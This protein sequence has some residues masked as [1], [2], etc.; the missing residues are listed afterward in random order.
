MCTRLNTLITIAVVVSLLS[1][2]LIAAAQDDPMAYD[3]KI[4]VAAQ[5]VNETV[6]LA[7]MAKVLLDEQTSLD[8]TINTDF[9]A[10]SVL[11]Q[12]M[13]GDEID[14]YPTWTGTQLTGILRYEGPNLSSE[15]TYTLVKQGFE[16]KFNMTWSEPMGFNN[17]YIMAVHQE[18]AD[19]YNLQKASD[20]KDYAP[21][22]ILAGDEN[23]DTRSDAYPG[24]SEAYGIE[25]KDVLPMQYA[26]I[27]QAIANKEVDV[28]AAYSTDSRIEKLNLTL[29]PDDKGFFPDYSAAFV[30]QMDLVEKFPK[31]LDI[32]N[33]LG[34]KI[35]EPTMSAMNLEYDSGG[36][37]ETIARE[38]LTSAGLLK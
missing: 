8:T 26:M 6:I 28:I 35:D 38:F 23:F 24:W 13:A 27:Y 19:E 14:I 2:S 31:V 32:I 17:T 4:R 36:D 22:W 21:D 10:S 3:G 34:G 30:L 18:T 12:A 11:H 7:W 33:Q 1:F 25:F 9:A 16:E 37:P 20:L 15:E 5:T 29:L